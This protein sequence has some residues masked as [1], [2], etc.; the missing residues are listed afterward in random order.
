MPRQTVEEWAT[1]GAVLGGLVALSV[2]RTTEDLVLKR[3]L[4]NAS[5]LPEDIIKNIENEKKFG[6]SVS[7]EFVTTVLIDN[8]FL[9]VPLCSGI[10]FLFGA[11]AGTVTVTYCSYNEMTS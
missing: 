5:N 9:W 7:Q 6:T 10:G 11:V 8:R 1:T 4:V 3:D 2:A